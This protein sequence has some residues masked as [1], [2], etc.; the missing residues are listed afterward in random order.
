MPICNDRLGDD[1]MYHFFVG[2]L[3]CII[4]GCLVAHI[5]PHLPFHTAAIAV[6]TV[7]FLAVVWEIYR[8]RLP[9]NHISVWDVL[10]SV[11]G[12]V[13]FSWI[14]WLAARYLAIDS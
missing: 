1:K 14:P 5:P 13:C 7:L 4:A 3:I 10:W 12:A 9:G 8:M 11:I 2:A 6:L